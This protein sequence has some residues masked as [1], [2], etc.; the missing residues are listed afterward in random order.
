MKTDEEKEKINVMLSVN[1]CLYLATMGG[2]GVLHMQDQIGSFDVGKQFDTQLIS[3]DVPNSNVQLFYWQKLN[4]TK[5]IKG[6]RN[7]PPLLNH[8]DIIAKW[9]FNGDD[10]NVK[11]TWV[12]GQL[13]HSKDI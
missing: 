1:E 12:S 11:Y 9:F 7:Q 2:A 10:R 4:G 6:I 3:L 5:A 13:V 8:E